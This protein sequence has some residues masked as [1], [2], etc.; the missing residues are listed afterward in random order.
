MEQAKIEVHEE[1]VQ[2]ERGRPAKEEKKLSRSINLKLTEDDYK[3]IAQKAADI[4]MKPT[5]Y[6]RQMVLNGKIK[7]RYTKEELDLRRKIAGMANNLNQITRKAN[8]G[9]FDNVGWALIDLWEDL[10]KLLDDR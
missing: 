5:Q 6:A 3:A 8:A 4:G 10:R 2:R 7:P 1:P 9:G